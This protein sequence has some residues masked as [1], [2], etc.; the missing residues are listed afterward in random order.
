MPV[1]LSPSLR[2]AVSMSSTSCRSICALLRLRQ[3]RKM[4][5][6]VIE[7]AVMTVLVMNA[8][9]KQR[10]EERSCLRQVLR[11]PAVSVATLRYTRA[12]TASILLDS[13]I[14]SRARAVNRV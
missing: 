4:K 11:R 1:S 3:Y 12:R 14:Q 7:T 8:V 9:C 6:A 2:D 13:R 5:H 10:E